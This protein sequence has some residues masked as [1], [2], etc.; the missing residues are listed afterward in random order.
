[1][2]FNGN[3]PPLS[4]PIELSGQIHS[5]WGMDGF[6]VQ[7]ILWITS[8]ARKKLW[9]GDLVQFTGYRQDFDGSLM[10]VRRLGTL[11]EVID[12]ASSW[13]EFGFWMER[14]PERA[15]SITIII[16]PTWINFSLVEYIRYRYQVAHPR[17]N[18]RANPHV[19]E[20]PSTW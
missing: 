14:T 5:R 13:V 12:V 1:M 17:P 10:P 20:Y 9:T 8:S 11:G 3:S 18:S 4:Q 2:I 19:F 16:P 6:P 15:V 7:E